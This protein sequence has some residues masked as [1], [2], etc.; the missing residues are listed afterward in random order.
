MINNNERESFISIHKIV[1]NGPVVSLKNKIKLY[2]ST[3]GYILG[4][5]KLNSFQDIKNSIDKGYP[6]G[7]LLMRNLFDWHWIMAIGYRV[8]NSGEKYLRV[9]DGWH[10]TYDNF[11]RIN[12]GSYCISKREYFIKN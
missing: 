4:D 7:L 3:R 12:Y 11:Y 6:V 5:N 8:Y 2:F 1:G 10:N 9:V